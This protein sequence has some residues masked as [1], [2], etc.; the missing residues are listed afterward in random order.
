[1]KKG[2]HQK[3]PNICKVIFSSVKLQPPEKLTYEKYLMTCQCQ[4]ESRPVLRDET[5]LLVRK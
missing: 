1:M 2:F 4:T 5:V 3:V